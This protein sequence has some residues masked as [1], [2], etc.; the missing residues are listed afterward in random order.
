MLVLPTMILPPTVNKL[1]D[2]V[3]VKLL[4]STKSEPP[5]LEAITSLIATSPAVD[6]TSTDEK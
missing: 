2:G 5:E 4:L 3:N 1:V 6:V